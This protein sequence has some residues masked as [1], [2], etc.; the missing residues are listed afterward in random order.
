[1]IPS[2]HVRK[3]RPRSLSDLPRVILLASRGGGNPALCW[4]L[5]APIIWAGRHSHKAVPRDL[6]VLI[7]KKQ[8]RI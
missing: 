5:S 4:Y 6:K 3:L 7:S 2:L 8:S 1:M